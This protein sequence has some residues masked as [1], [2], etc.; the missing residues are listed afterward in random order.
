MLPENAPSEFYDR[1]VL[2]NSVE[3]VEKAKNSQLAREIT[4]ALPVELTS[5]QNIYLVREY[6]QKNFVDEG[7]IADLS[8]HN[9]RDGTN[10]HAHIML[11]M[12]PLDENGE[13]GVK[14][15]KQYILDDEGNK[16]YDPKKRQYKCGKIETMA[17]NSRDKAEH[18]REAWA[19]V[20]NEHLEQHNH[21]DRIDHKSFE[22]QGKTDQIPTIHLGASAHQMEKKGIRTERGDINRKIAATNNLL[23]ELGDEISNLQNK[24]AYLENQILEEQ[25]W[26]AE[27]EENAIPPTFADFVSDIL[28]KQSQSFIKP[29]FATQIFDFLKSKA[30]D[31]YEDIERYVKN[32]LNKQSSITHELS[33]IK[34]KL[35]E[36]NDNQQRIAAYQKHKDKYDQYQ[37]GLSS[38]LPWKKK[39][40]EREH[41]WIVGVFN[42]AKDNVEGLRNDKGKFPTGAWERERKHL[43]AKIQSL[44]GR[45]SALKS[46]VDDV[47]KIR[48]KVYDVLRKER[49]RERGQ[50]VRLQGL[51][52]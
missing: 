36:I 24:I 23:R 17:W 3:K 8:I 7:M 20:V 14:Q 4:V 15:R 27:E 29:Q 13:W 39:A 48:T 43:T 46:E 12:R 33:P 42:N 31:S 47:H 1:S 30:I 10:P 49:Q 25:R 22:R 38:Q 18:W 35:A 21:P 6:V 37:K 19:S 5:S 16:I 2:W 34:K 45:Y 32:L 50:P 52:R 41:G 28:S 26:L 44:N 40:F 9:N 51:E 11:T